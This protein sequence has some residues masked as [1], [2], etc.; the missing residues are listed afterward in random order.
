M[1]VNNQDSGKAVAVISIT[2][3]Q[4]D[5]T[6]VNKGAQ[7]SGPQVTPHLNATITQCPFTRKE[8]LEI[9]NNNKELDSTEATSNDK[10]LGEKE[11][12]VIYNDPVASELS[13]NNTKL[14]VELGNE[15]DRQHN[16]SQQVNEAEK[17]VDIQQVERKVTGSDV[18]NDIQQQPAVIAP[19]GHNNCKEE[20]KVMID[21]N[22]NKMDT[23]GAT[24]IHKLLAKE[25]TS[26][27]VAS[28]ALLIDNVA[29]EHTKEHNKQ[30]V[31][32]AM[33]LP[34]SVGV[35]T[36]IQRPPD[37]KAFGL[38]AKSSFRKVDDE[39]GGAKKKILHDVERA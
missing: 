37:G 25:E 35:C 29:I 32:I 19:I 28:E 17:V 36:D 20:L 26:Y 15:E 5:C 4:K 7:Q 9:I 23:T 16:N 34:T 12:N 10:L 21:N 2:E 22:N 33:L 30:L 1:M 39:G 13:L 8:E 11:V 14:I 18:F 27:P 38:D 24:S 31:N 3:E 6:N